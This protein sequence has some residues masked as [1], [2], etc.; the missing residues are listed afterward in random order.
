LARHIAAAG[1]TIAQYVVA[2]SIARP[3][4]ARLSADA[5]AWL[6]RVQQDGFCT[7]PDFYDRQTCS[8]AV[9][10]LER[11]FAQYPDFV[12]RKSD[13]RMFGVE[14]ASPLLRQ[15]ACE[16]NLLALA[17]A[18]LQAPTVNA[19]TLG[20]RIDYSSNNAGSGEGWHRDSFVVQF[21]AIVYL[22]D[23]EA[24]TGPF[25]LIADSEKLAQLASDMV[26][27]RLGLLQNRVQEAQVQRLLAAKPER[28]R[29]FTAK[30]GT[31]LL[32]NT[33]AIH[34]GKPIA[35]GTRHALTN[36]YVQTRQAGPAMHAHF[37]PVLRSAHRE[38]CIP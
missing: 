12:Q 11:L 7:V 15:F 30:A 31:L 29:T 2:R 3:S 10:E 20:A 25:Q 34:R 23:V 5:A 37:A 4:R 28:L 38:P 32:A 14:A 26:R 17:G 22:C 9:A 6:R 21:K 33:S 8:L 24:D 13:R 18:V 19:F 27:G 35:Q 36:Y 16:P 1:V